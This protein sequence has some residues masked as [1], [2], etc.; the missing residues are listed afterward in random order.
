MYQ[1]RIE[2]DE[3]VRYLAEMFPKCFFENP[4]HRRPLKHDIVIDLEQKNILDWTKLLHAIDWYQSHFTYRRSLLAGAERIDL[5]GRK[6]G[7]VTPKEQQEARKWVA[8]RKRELLEQRQITEQPHRTAVKDI[9]IEPALNGI[10]VPGHGPGTPLRASLAPLHGTLVAT[11]GIM[12]DERYAALRPVLVAAALRELIAGAE[13]VINSLQRCQKTDM[14]PLAFELLEDLYGDRIWFA[15]YD[16]P[17]FVSPVGACDRNKQKR[18]VGFLRGLLQSCKFLE[19]TEVW[20]LVGEL[21][22]KMLGDFEEHDRVDQRLAFLPAPQTWIEI[23]Q[24]TMR[25]I[26]ADSDSINAF[27]CMTPEQMAQAPYHYRSAFVFLSRDDTSLSL[28]DCF[29]IN[30]KTP[31]ASAEPRIWNVRR[32]PPLPLV[33]SGLKPQRSVEHYNQRGQKKHFDEPAASVQDFIDYAALSLI[34]SP[35]IVGQ[36]GHYPQWPRRARAPEETEA[37]RQVSATSV[38][39]DPAPR[40]A[41]PGR[42]QRRCTQGGAS[43]RRALPALL[44]HISA[45]APRHAR[46]RR[47]SLARKSRSGNQTKSLPLGERA[48]ACSRLKLADRPLILA[49]PSTRDARWRTIECTR[50]AGGW[51]GKKHRRTPTSHRT[52]SGTVPCRPR[53]HAGQGQE[54]KKRRRRPWPTGTSEQ[55]NQNVVRT[56]DRGQPGHGI[57][58]AAGGARPHAAAVDDHKEGIPAGVDDAR[59]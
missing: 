30:Y 10:T 51:P 52:A 22:V 54:T 50:P 36:R 14:T 8:E 17:G 47:G 24:P 1:H 2:R 12:V 37:D 18:M 26:V 35:R 43:D 5:D 46:V 40:R 56:H 25:S 42:P 29:L 13:R 58:P 41:Q 31:R 53:S 28:A 27:V 19:C 16:A 59:H 55:R 34:N 15:H 6:A 23:E 4:D 44:P 7:T 32:M 49:K 11:S 9:P 33:G 39:R 48:P 45:R 38:D 3:A 21:A 20:P 57:A